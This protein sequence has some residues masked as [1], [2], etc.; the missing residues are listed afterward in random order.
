MKQTVA[1]TGGSGFIGS[2]VIDALLDAGHD[3]RVLDPV[4]PH[5]AEAEWVPVD[6]LDTEA[7]TETVRGMDAVMHLAAIADVNHVFERPVDSVTL[8]VAGTASVLEATRRAEAGRV[9]LAST[10]WVYA[11]TRGHLVDETTPF[12]PE[13]DRHLYVSTKVASEMMCR[14]YHTLYDRPYTILRYGVPYGPRMRDNCV[15]A[16]FFQRAFRGEPLHIDGDGTQERFLVYVGDLARA[17]VLALSGAAVNRTFNLD[18]DQPVSIREIAEAV[19]ELTG[20]VTVEFG[21]ARPGDL[22]ARIVKTDRARDELGWVP[23]VAFDEGMRLTY[24]WY[25]AEMDAPAAT[26]VP[27]SIV[28]RS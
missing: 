8:N 24:E 7:L 12:D 14:D 4:A 2:H 25:L 26:E 3:V 18:G 13:T 20:N 1:V 17:H 22:K 6:I 27:I 5:R 9:I 21:P 11:A 28:E 16:A 19:K 23:Q 10:V 15:A